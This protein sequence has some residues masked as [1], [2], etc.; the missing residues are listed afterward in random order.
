LTINKPL[1]QCLQ[2]VLDT[3]ISVAQQRFG[4]NPGE[5]AQRVMKY[6]IIIVILPDK[7]G[8][9]RNSVKHW[10]DTERGELLLLLNS[11]L[12]AADKGV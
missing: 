4:G 6:L 1:S 10:G 5:V 8:P 9:I 11:C 12:L 7:A 3:A 2:E